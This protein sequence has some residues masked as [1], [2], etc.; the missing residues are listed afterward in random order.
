NEDFYEG[1]PQYENGVGMVR[2]LESE[3]TEALEEAC[4]ETCGT[5]EREISDR[6]LWD[7]ELWDRELW[8]RELSIATGVLAYD[9]IKMLTDRLKEKFPRIKCHV[10]K[11]VNKF[12]GETI[13]VA[14]LLTAGDIISQLKG[15][16]LGSELLLTS[17]MIKHD[18][19]LF[20]D[21]MRICD[22]EKELNVKIRLVNNDGRELFEAI[23][24]RL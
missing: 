19:D 14:G 4:D 15:V 6:E 7:R 21:D 17:S 8:D 23:T 1:Y 20:L 16:P 12:F 18:S 5:G 9:L 2:S 11:I 22:V 13:T 24:G 3:F 10:Y